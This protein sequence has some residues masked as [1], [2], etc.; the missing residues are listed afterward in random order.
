M[1][2]TQVVLRPHFEKHCS[3]TVI[4]RHCQSPS[5]SDPPP[6][7]PKVA[8]ELVST[9]F[10]LLS[11][12]LTLMQK[13]NK[14]YGSVQLMGLIITIAN[15]LSFLPSVSSLSISFY[16]HSQGNII[17]LSWEWKMREN[18]CSSPENSHMQFLICLWNTVIWQDESLTQEFWHSAFVPERRLAARRPRPEFCVEA[19]QGGSA[20]EACANERL[21]LQAPS[22]PLLSASLLQTMA[23]GAWRTEQ[24]PK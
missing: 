3:G 6:E 22:L 16:L 1:F 17:L 20:A 10:L 13:D 5:S 2:L 11:S 4:T 7:A 21:S 9:S 12:F 23:E 18:R 15:N 8:G 24:H 14:L 19:G